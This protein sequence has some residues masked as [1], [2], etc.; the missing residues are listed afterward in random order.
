MKI[1]KR[2]SE[3]N[4]E[5]DYQKIKPLGNVM[6]GGHLMEA[7]PLFGCFM[8]IKTTKNHYESIPDN[9]LVSITFRVPTTMI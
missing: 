9:L 7:S 3:S 2:H 4:D 1:S 6:L 8:T 5:N